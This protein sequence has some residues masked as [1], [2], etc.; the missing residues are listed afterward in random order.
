MVKVPIMA[1]PSGEIGPPR[2]PGISACAP[3]LR[4]HSATARRFARRQRV[5]V[6]GQ[7]SKR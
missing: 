3:P 4:A 5:T 1:M 6:G 7:Y 2:A